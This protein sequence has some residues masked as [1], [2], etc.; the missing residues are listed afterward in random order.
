MDRRFEL[1][2]EALLEEAQV[3][4]NVFRENLE[5]L[6]KFTAPFAALLVRSE[7]REHAARFVSGL[8]SDLDRKNTESIAYRHDQD[9][10]DLQNFI[11]QSEWN[12]Q[13]LLMELGKQ[14]GETLGSPDG[15]L[16]FDPSGFPKKGTESVGV[17]RQWCGRLGKV[18]NCQLGV[19]MGYVSGEEHALVNMRLYL[20]KEWAKDRKRRKKCRVPRRIRFKKRYELC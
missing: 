11:G 19:Y 9:R 8:L 1:R 3:S 13:P 5:R 18:E 16:V 4:L 12:H 6:E 2:K 17:V 14:V 15:V 20:S 7:Q 10:K